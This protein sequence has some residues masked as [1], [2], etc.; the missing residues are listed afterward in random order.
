[1]D[2]KLE[3]ALL[4]EVER[5]RKLV[6]DMCVARCFEERPLPYGWPSGETVNLLRTDELISHAKDV[7]QAREQNQ[8]FMDALRKGT[9]DDLDD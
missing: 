4:A 1:M 6:S 8:G 3:K 2:L 7:I 9:T 5:L